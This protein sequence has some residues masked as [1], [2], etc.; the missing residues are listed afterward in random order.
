MN[1]LNY[2]YE[3]L[4]SFKNILRIPLIQRKPLTPK[5]QIGI[6]KVTGRFKS[7]RNQLGKSWEFV[8][9][10]FDGDAAEAWCS[11]LIHGTFEI[12]IDNVWTQFNLGEE[13]EVTQEFQEDYPLIETSVR[14]E[15]TAKASS[16]KTV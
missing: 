16:N 8:T 11:A 14:L 4:T 15:E 5:T 9:G 10:W 3:T 13:S 1:I 7:V 6:S 2:N 12:K